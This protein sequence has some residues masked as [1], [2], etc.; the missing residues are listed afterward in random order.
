MG[1]RQAGFRQG[2]YQSV[3]GREDALVM[4]LTS[5]PA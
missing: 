3:A 5:A 1:F 2:Y 4:R